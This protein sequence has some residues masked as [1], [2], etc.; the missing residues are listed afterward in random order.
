[1]AKEWTSKEY[2]HL[3]NGWRKR[4]FEEGENATGRL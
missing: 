4:N 3:S 1:L 2:S